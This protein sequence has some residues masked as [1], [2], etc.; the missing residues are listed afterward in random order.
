MRAKDFLIETTITHN[1][2][3]QARAALASLDQ[4]DPLRKD[5]SNILISIYKDIQK[6][7]DMEIDE[8]VTPTEEIALQMIDSPEALKVLNARTMESKKAALE[9]LINAVVQKSYTRGHQKGVVTGKKKGMEEYLS[10]DAD[11]KKMLGRLPGSDSVG[12]VASMRTVFRRPGITEPAAKLFLKA[13]ASGQVIDMIKLVNSK[14]KGKGEK[15]DDYVRPELKDTFTKIISDFLN[16][17]PGATGGNIGPGE[18]AFILL[19]SPTSKVEKGDLLIG[20]E[21]FEVKASSESPGKLTK[22][23]EAGAPKASGAIFGADRMNNGKALWPSIKKILNKHGIEQT[24]ELAT[25]KGKTGMAPMFK[26]NQRGLA[27]YNA[28]FEK[29]RF[30]INQSAHVL[31]DILKKMYPS[32]VTP[33]SEVYSDLVNILRQSNGR[34]D[35]NINGKLMRYIAMIALRV[36]RQ[37][38]GK[39]N[40][41]FFNK[42]TRDFRVYRGIDLDKDL[43]NPDGDLKVIR[44]I[45]WNDGSYKISP[46]IYLKEKGQ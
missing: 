45:D 12:N 43:M 6:H 38:P 20:D 28:A 5:L 13:A 9:A 2:L 29:L 33:E 24:E 36:Y 4:D 46:G 32:V 31:H 25:R 11:I 14:K 41:I 19:G 8:T 40:F 7:M 15:I 37:D 39:D 26:F 10:S 27:Q 44:G 3:T 34:I 17:I 16:F 30:D 1:T 18:V 35:E 21:K 23:G 22:S 42:T